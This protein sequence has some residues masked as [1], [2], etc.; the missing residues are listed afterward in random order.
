MPTFRLDAL[1]LFR[2]LFCCPQK[3]LRCFSGEKLVSKALCWRGAY[4]RGALRIF[5]N[6]P[7]SLFGPGLLLKKGV[8][9]SGGYGTHKCPYTYIGTYLIG[10]GPTV[11]SNSTMGRL[12]KILTD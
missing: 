8:L 12:W 1:V 10:I 7:P 3:N 9:F 2:A 11:N 4:I 6:K 5:E